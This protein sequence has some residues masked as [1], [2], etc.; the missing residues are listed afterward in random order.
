MSVNINKNVEYKFLEYQSS[1]GGGTSDE[2]DAINGAAD[3]GWELV[4]IE[5]ASGANGRFGTGAS[6]S[7]IFLFKR[8]TYSI[9][10]D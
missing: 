2:I 6:G 9:T 8:E 3:G 7:H 10:I 1:L 4:P 5:N